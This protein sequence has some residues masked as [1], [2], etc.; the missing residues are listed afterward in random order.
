MGKEKTHEDH[1]WPETE[2]GP[3]E[4]WNFRTISASENLK[5]G[6]EMPTVNDVLDSSN[7][8]KLAA[9]IDKASLEG[10]HHSRNKGKGFGGLPRR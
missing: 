3:T 7:P 1:I 8:I 6:A 5:K 2:G 10:F 9:E 4:A